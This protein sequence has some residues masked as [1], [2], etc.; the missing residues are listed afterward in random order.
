MLLYPDVYWGIP[1]VSL[2]NKE[3]SSSMEFVS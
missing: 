1:R 3:Y 2:D